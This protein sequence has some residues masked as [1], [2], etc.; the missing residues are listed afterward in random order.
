MRCKQVSDL[1]NRS[2]VRLNY[3]ADDA[4]I[5]PVPGGG[6]VLDGGSLH[7][8]R[9]AL[10]VWLR[11][12]TVEVGGAVS[13]KASTMVERAMR[14]QPRRLKNIAYGWSDKGAKRWWASS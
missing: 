8:Q 4:E 9:Q 5:C 7:R 13:N 10:R 11:Q 12:K 2:L 1:T 14:E 6:M 3:R